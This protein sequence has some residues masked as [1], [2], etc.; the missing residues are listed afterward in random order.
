M[1][2]LDGHSTTPLDPLV[3]EAMK[4]YFLERFGNASHG[5]H[6]FNWEA[7][8]GLNRAREQ[9]AKALGAHEKEIIFTGGAT[10]ANHIAILGSAQH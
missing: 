7:E 3:F 1:I 8:A 9:I 10:E 4:P 5:L 2:Y 6:R